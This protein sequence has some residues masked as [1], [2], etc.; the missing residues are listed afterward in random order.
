[1]SAHAAL[2]GLYLQA[3]HRD[4]PRHELL[5]KRPQAPGPGPARNASASAS[6][7]ARRT[8]Q[9]SQLHLC[10][11]AARPVT[12]GRLPAHRPALVS[13]LHRHRLGAGSVEP[14]AEGAPSLGKVC[15]WNHVA[16][17]VDRGSQ[18]RIARQGS[19]DDEPPHLTQVT[20]FTTACRRSGHSG[21]QGRA[22]VWM[23]V[24]IWLDALANEA[25]YIRVIAK[26][27]LITTPPKLRDCRVVDAVLTKPYI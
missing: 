8:R 22:F 2:R 3:A 18:L 9:M 11:A 24:S 17:G 27:S 20:Y 7:I 25:P 23:C 13:A 21:S 19:P 6:P 26:D 1:V 12:I 10:E 16:S 14:L 5:S 15:R 4:P